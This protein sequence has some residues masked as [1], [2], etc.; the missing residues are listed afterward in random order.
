MGQGHE[1]N[2]ENQ[3]QA[4]IALAMGRRPPELLDYLVGPKWRACH[5]GASGK[6]TAFPED[7]GCPGRALRIY[8]PWRWNRGRDKRCRRCGASC[9]SL[10]HVQNHCGPHAVAR[11]KRHDDIVERLVK[12][13]KVPGD[14]A[15]NRAVQ[16]LQGAAAALRHD[17]VVR[18]E[19]TRRVL[20]IDICPLRKP[21]SGVRRGP[22]G[23][24]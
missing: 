4:R 20:L 12:A 7:Q 17:L 6:T 10:P 21:H 18:N 15:V 8:H 24:N 13:S 22:P 3:D 19:A 16:G 23:K 5:H 9:E 1:R 2:R 14:V 11:Q